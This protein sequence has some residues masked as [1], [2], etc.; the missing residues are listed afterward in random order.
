MIDASGAIRRQPDE[1]KA[2]R[3][4]FLQA[5]TPAALGGAARANAFEDAILQSGGNLAQRPGCRTLIG[6]VAFPPRHTFETR[7]DWSPARVTS[8][9]ARALQG[10]QL[11]RL[12]AP[13]GSSAKALDLRRRTSPRLSAFLCCR[14]QC[15]LAS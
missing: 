2:L 9:I 11:A 1:S 14:W 8:I 4:A 15:T 13:C 7:C 5:T 10:D 6:L 12:C 3:V